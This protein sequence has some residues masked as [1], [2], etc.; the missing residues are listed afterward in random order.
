QVTHQ[1]I[2]YTVEPYQAQEN[3][4]YLNPD[5]QERKWPLG[6]EVIAV[7]QDG[8]D[9]PQGVRGNIPFKQIYVFSFTANLESP[10]IP[11]LDPATY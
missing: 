10:V 11:I 3:G 2:P 9:G 6:H 4:W 7:I 1:E 8:A 5:N